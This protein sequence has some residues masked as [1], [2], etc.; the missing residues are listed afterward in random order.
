MR[1]RIAY[2]LILVLA[3]ALAGVSGYLFALYGRQGESGTYPYAVPPIIGGQGQITQPAQ[4]KTIVVTGFGRTFSKPDLA[5]LRLGVMTEATT[6]TEALTKNAV[7][8]DQVIKALKALGIAE[9]RIE[10]SY[11]SLHPRYSTYGRTLIGFEVIHM[12]KVTTTNIDDVGR[13]I[14]KA[15][16]AGANRVDGV[17]FIFTRERLQELNGIARRMAVED[18]KSKAEVIANSLGVKIVGVAYAV[19][20]AYHY[21]YYYMGVELVALPTPIMPPAEVGITVIVRVAYIIE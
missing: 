14:D 8:T 7:S 5:E 9:E 3:V 20:E 16:E 1:E 6:A 4:L 13:I 2:G 18:A 10:T 19:E 15:V 21:P 11:F 12:L 17:C